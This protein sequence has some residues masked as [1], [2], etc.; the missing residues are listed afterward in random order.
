MFALAER[1]MAQLTF[2]FKILLLTLLLLLPLLA[3]LLPFATQ[4]LAQLEHIQQAQSTRQQLLALQPY[5]QQR[6]RFDEARQLARFGD[7][8]L[9]ATPA[10]AASMPEPLNTE[11]SSDQIT[12]VDT[13]VQWLS[14]QT[15]QAGLATFIDDPMA[16]ALWSHGHVSWQLELAQLNGLIR[17][18]QQQGRFTPEL[19]LALS[20]Q[21]ERLNRKFKGLN[22]AM[23]FAAEARPDR[24]QHLDPSV[25]IRQY[26][27]WVQRH[28]IDA[29][30]V[31]P[32]LS[33]PQQQTALLQRLSATHEQLDGLIARQLTDARAAIQHS[34]WLQSGLLALS[35]LMAVWLMTG[36][37]RQMTAMVEAT[38]D[39]ATEFAQ[40]NL[41]AR[42]TLSGRDEL[43]EIG[44][45][46]NALAQATRT[47]VTDTHHATGAVR[48]QSE[49]MQQAATD[50]CQATGRQDAML[51]NI[52]DANGHLAHHA[53]QMADE[54]RHDVDRVQT[55]KHQMQQGLS[56]M[57]DA[58]LEVEGVSAR[59]HQAHSITDQL[60]KTTEQIDSVVSEIA[61]IAEQTNLLALN[62]AIEAARAGEQGRG[63][64]V[65]ADE[66]RT[67]AT[68]TAG[69]T[70]EIR[71]M[72]EN[73]TSTTAEVVTAMGLSTAQ[74]NSADERV[75]RL[76]DA[77][78]SL[79][80]GLTGILN[81][82]DRVAERCRSQVS[83]TEQVQQ[84]VN[85]S[86]Q[87]LHSAIAAGEQ[88]SDNSRS[89]QQLAAALDQQLRHYR[90]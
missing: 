60:D 42:I 71:R 38:R 64:A 72:I 59:I 31:D 49:Q 8:P 2:R 54:T 23:V 6:W 12:D 67:L 39:A 62:A 21:L 35:L 20:A 50:A 84:L 77:L 65:V 45:Q 22:G 66:V 76:A 36:F 24:W 81:S 41:S 19:Y 87:Q 82:S 40:G 51:A 15:N 16:L 43:N 25:Q 4:K 32:S 26:L 78:Q 68:R 27:D 58:R 75:R 34:L 74:A 33:A 11:L 13:V 90:L 69:S 73:V 47:L 57:T 17:A 10:A 37:Y 55:L 53:R 46:F 7:A 56:L 18:L 3:L 30:E 85:D 52:Q 14:G 79:E 88:S 70:S 9:P 29:D 48:Q 61:Q 80:Q 28:F 44:R 63:F 89:L 5:W 86:Q 83:L 1:L